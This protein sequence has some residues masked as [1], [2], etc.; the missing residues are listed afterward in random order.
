MQGR[1]STTKPGT[2][3]AF[4]PQARSNAGIAAVKGTKGE[5]GASAFS[6]HFPLPPLQKHVCPNPNPFHTSH[7]KYTGGTHQL[8]L[9]LAEHVRTAR[10]IS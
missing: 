5:I 7:K 3:K 4:D 10:L 9:K 1:V 8:A 2:P 6:R